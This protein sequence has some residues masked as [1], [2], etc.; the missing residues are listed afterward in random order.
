MAR[1]ARHVKGN[2]H[3]CQK[4]DEATLEILVDCRQNSSSTTWSTVHIV[5]IGMKLEMDS[6]QPA[7]DKS[8][9]RFVT[10]VRHEGASRP[11]CSKSYLRLKASI[12]VISVA[13]RR[14]DAWI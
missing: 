8:P 11:T 9:V 10:A 12:T 13:I 1:S 3:K 2:F 4:N 6:I 7:A 5:V 14:L